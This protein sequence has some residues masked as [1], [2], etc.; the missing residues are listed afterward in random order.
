MRHCDGDCE[1][2]ECVVCPFSRRSA[3]IDTNCTGC[4]GTDKRGAPVYRFIARLP[5]GE[6]AP[7]TWSVSGGDPAAGAGSISAAGEYTPPGYLT[8]DQAQVVV[9]ARLASDPRVAASAQ[10]TVTPGFLQPLTPENVALGPNGTVTVTGRLALAGGSA[11]IRFALG[12]WRIG[13]KRRP[14]V[15]GRDDLPAIEQGFHGVL[16]DVHSALDHRV[17]RRDLPCG[18]AHE[19]KRSGDTGEDGHADPAEH[20]G[21]DQQSGRAP[22][23]TAH[24]D[25][26]RAARAAT[27]TILTRA[28]T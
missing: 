28:A 17:D 23:A 15:A 21:S 12:E 16:G 9:T 19:I 25:A 8:A 7:V 6:A 14:G 13:R 20:G 27:I 26:A 24:A 11:G 1:P 5:N 18:E 4:N 22:V 3:A 2:G 10:M